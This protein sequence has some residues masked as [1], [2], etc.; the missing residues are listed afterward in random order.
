MILRSFSPVAFALILAGCHT[1]QLPAYETSRDSLFY[2]Q[3][4]TAPGV[5]VGAFI[6][7]PPSLADSSNAE[8]IAACS[9]SVEQPPEA[10]ANYRD[11]MRRALVQE[12]STAGLYTEDKSAPQITGKIEHLSLARS[13]P[14]GSAWDVRLRLISSNGA[15]M[16]T[17]ERFPFDNGALAGP[18]VCQQAIR[19]F[20]STVQSLYEQAVRS[21]EFGQ[22]LQSR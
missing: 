14:F 6:G 3:Q 20:G 19:A 15:Q 22:L 17:E 1:P 10:P 16:V 2:L 11:Y 7:G 12:L 21:S 18:T 8:T 13:A 9:L 4:I 5:S